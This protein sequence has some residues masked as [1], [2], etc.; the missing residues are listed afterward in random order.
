MFPITYDMTITYDTTNFGTFWLKDA[1]LEDSDKFPEP[2]ILA[3]EI[4][5]QLEAALEEFRT[6]ETLFS[7]EEE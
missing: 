7:P 4:A 2:V 5:E 6:I 3:A 1:S